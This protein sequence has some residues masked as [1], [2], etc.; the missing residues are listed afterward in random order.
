MII[1]EVLTLAT[2]I[3]V[4]V[5]QF[6]LADRANARLDMIEARLIAL[7]VVKAARTRIN[8]DSFKPAGEAK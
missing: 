8:E 4:L 1:F 7:A 2:C 3:G 5:N 6:T